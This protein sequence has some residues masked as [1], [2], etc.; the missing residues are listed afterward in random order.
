M[1]PTQRSVCL[2]CTLL[3]DDVEFQ[4]QGRVVTPLTDCPRCHRWVDN[5]NNHLTLTAG[6]TPDANAALLDRFSEQIARCLQSADAPLV[7]GLNHLTTQAQQWAWRSSDIAGA[8]IDVTLGGDSGADIY[9]FQRYGKVTATI[10]EIANRGDLIVFWFCDPQTTH[11]RLIQRLNKSQSAANKKIVVIE[12]ADSPP[13]ATATAAVADVVFRVDENQAVDFIREIRAV[14]HGVK[15]PPCDRDAL[16][17]A[18]SDSGAQSN[19]SDAGRDDANCDGDARSLATAM[20]QC[21]YGS[22]IHGPTGQHP[23]WDEVTMAS[24]RMIRDLNDHT[25]FISFALRTDQNAISGENVLAAFSGFPVA[26]NLG[27]AQP[28]YNGAEFSAESILE[29]GECDFVLWVA[30]YGTE[31]ELMSLSPSARSFFDSVPKIVVTT[32][33]AFYTTAQ[34]RLIITRPGIDDH[35][36]WV[37]LDDVSLGVTAIKGLD[38][39]AGGLGISGESLFEAVF[40]RMVDAAHRAS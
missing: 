18:R 10:G 14:L 8:V 28:S 36:E 4:I 5:A 25:R 34:D 3:C 1:N 33:A 22:W 21:R 24:Q 27:S 20:M 15:S 2:G 35:G 30:G 12:S 23:R 16:R 40:H 6:Q 7:V 29:N 32:D 31:A 19:P 9:A 13:T 37:R 38:G 17:V 26:V 11:P 39:I